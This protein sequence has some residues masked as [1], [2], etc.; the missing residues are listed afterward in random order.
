MGQ[1]GMGE[2]KTLLITDRNSN[3]RDLLR[4]DLTTAG[5]K[6]RVAR[7]HSEVLKYLTWPTPVD[8]LILDPGIVPVSLSKFFKS[9]ENRLPNVPIILHGFNIAEVEQELEYSNLIR[10]EK[11]AKSIDMIIEILK[12]LNVSNY[13]ED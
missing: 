2:P 9:I 3:V 6:V 1:R 5:Y 8:V 13:K 4:R 12:E 10:L 11:N 7:S